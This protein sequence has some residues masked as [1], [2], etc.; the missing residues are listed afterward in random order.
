MN[1]FSVMN[2][3]LHFLR[4]QSAQL[5]ASVV[6]NNKNK[7]E[8][9]D[10]FFSIDSFN[11]LVSDPLRVSMISF[12]L[13]DKY[14]Y[15]EKDWV[16]VR[17]QMSEK[18]EIFQHL[19]KV[20]ISRGARTQKVQKHLIFKP[21]SWEGPKVLKMLDRRISGEAKAPHLIQALFPVS[22]H[23]AKYEITRLLCDM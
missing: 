19:N 5:F 10:Q 8:F 13:N 4:I 23:L 20:Q 1:F 9:R 22:I 17:N 7:S 15:C 21:G 6:R 14:R 3:V 16:S 12:W 11:I 18:C 2:S